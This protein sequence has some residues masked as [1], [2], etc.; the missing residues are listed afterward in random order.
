MFPNVPN[1][2]IDSAAKY[3]KAGAATVGVAGSGAG[4]GN[5]FGAV[6]IVYA[7]IPSLKQ[8]LLTASEE[9]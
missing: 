3:I 9:K 8:Q 7:R 6:V 2:D 4:I 5:V 1:K